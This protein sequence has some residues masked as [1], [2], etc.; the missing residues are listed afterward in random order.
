[1]KAPAAV[2]TSSAK[3]AWYEARSFVML[4]LAMADRKLESFR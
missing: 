3:A 2:M 4:V 1:M